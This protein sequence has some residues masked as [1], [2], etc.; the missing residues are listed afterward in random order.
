MAYRKPGITITQEFAGLV[1]ALATFNLPSVA[2]GPAYQLVDD[3]PLGLYDG[4]QTV[5]PYGALIGGAIVDLEKLNPEEEF[6]ITKKPMSAQLVDAIAQ[7]AASSA[8]G[9]SVGVNFSDVTASRFANAQIG[10]LIRIVPTPGIEI[11]APQTAGAVS[12]A[13]PARITDAGKFANV[14]PGDLVEVS[15]GANANVGTYTVLTKVSN[16]LIIVD[17]DVNDGVGA[18]ADLAYSISGDRGVV[19]QGDYRIKSKTDDNNV[20]LEGGLSEDESLLTYTVVREIGD[21]VL[22]R[23]DALS[24]NGFVADEN[25]VSLPGSAILLYGGLEVVGGD[26]EV[27]YRALRTDFASKVFEFGDIAAINAQFGTGQIHPANPLAFALQVMKQNTVTAVH[28][29]GLSS[30]FAT[31]ETTAF[32][33]AADKLSL[34]EMYAL[35]ILT[36]SPVIHTLFKNHVEQMSLPERKRERVALINSKLVSVSVLQE[37]STTSADLNA[38]RTIVPTTLDGSGAVASPS[39]LSGS[40]NIFQNV[41]LG[42]KVKILGGT[43]VNVGTYTVTSIVDN[44]N[45][46]LS[47]PFIT[48]G[49]PIDIQ[50]VI[51]RADGLGFDGKEVYD[52]NAQFIS[53]GVAPGHFVKIVSPTGIAGRYKVGSV[54]SESLLILE[55]AINGVTTHQNP[56]TYQ[57]DRDLSKTE[58]A[59]AIKGYSESIGSRRVVH[60]WPDVI[61][62]PVGADVEKLPGFYLCAIVAGLTTGLPTQQGF[63]NLA[64]SGALGYEH[65]LGF[66]NDDQLNIIA[67]GGTMIFEQE[68]ENQPLYIRHQLTTDRSAIKFQEYSV[69][70]NV[71]F[72]AKFL[73][74]GFKR[75]IGPYN[76]IDTT[77]DDLK[78]TGSASIKFLREKTRLPKIGGVIKSG[79]LVKLE[80]NAEQI[81][82]VDMRFKVNIPIPLN[83]IDMVVEA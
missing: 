80:E 42:D 21:I 82:T 68:G 45:I 81:D 14:K 70:K 11:V 72:I 77:I 10:D 50:Y 16:D 73:R 20:V 61:E 67:D 39:T 43:D 40:G 49:S 52:R 19:T 51:V 75:F 34:T 13:E 18:T 71:D 9:S 35:A 38:A 26:L 31:D 7:V 15:G 55:T 24:E 59:E 46:E 83:N 66:F 12:V 5:Y 36:H 58:M 25:G 79:S 53:N 22:E 28:G 2:V 29:I 30:A 60:C 41:E 63:T 76:I 48:A 27:S 47:S 65:S 62:A 17:G 33:E 8:V 3:D 6:P 32:L 56:L 69:T 78:A 64:V 23:V 37:S 57:V 74:G 4:N 1:P 54:E 44:D